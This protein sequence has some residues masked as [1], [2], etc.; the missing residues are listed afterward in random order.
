MEDLFM[1][2]ASA[3][4]LKSAI[5]RSIASDMPSDNIEVLDLTT[6]GG[7]VKARAKQKNDIAMTNSTN[8]LLFD[9]MAGIVNNSM[10]AAWPNSLAS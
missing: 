6:A 8:A 7:R 10:D 2:F 1:V 4:R 3:N 5:G 9:G